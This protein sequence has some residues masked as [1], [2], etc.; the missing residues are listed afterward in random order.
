MIIIKPGYSVFKKE[1]KIFAHGIFFCLLFFEAKS[2]EIFEPVRPQKKIVPSKIISTINVD[3]RLDEAAWDSAKSINDFIEINPKQGSTPSQPTF[4]RI[5]YNNSYL[6]IAV[7]CMDKGGKKSIRATDFKRDFD[8]PYHDLFAIMIDGFKDARNAMAFLINPYGVQRDV[9]CFDDR[10]FDVE[11]DGLWKVRTQRT[12]SGWIAEIAIPW[13]TLRYPATAGAFQTWGIN[14]TRQRRSTNEYYSW[15]PF[16]R[17]YSLTR[18]SYEGLL[19]SLVVP[20]ASTNIRIQPYTLI[21]AEKEHL[22]SNWKEDVKEGGEI[23][24]ALASNKVLD[25][26]FN[27]DFAQADV[28]QQ[29]NN[30]QRFSIFFPERRQFFLENASLFKSGLDVNPDGNKG[31]QMTI[32]PFFS[33]KIG[34]DDNGNPI[35]IQAGAR[36]IQRGDKN[37]LGLMSV[38]QASSDSL[39]PA[40]FFIG[41]YTCGIGKQNQIGALITTRLQ[42]HAFNK[43]IEG[44][45]N[46][47]GTVDGFFR[48]SEKLQWN[49]MLSATS[50]PGKVEKGI[51][52]YSQVFYRND[53][54]NA[55]WNQSFVSRNYSPEIGFVNRSNI[56]CTSPGFYITDRG[57]W[58]PAFIR[59][60]DPGIKTDM[61][62]TLN[63]GKL[64]EINL[65]IFPV[66]FEFH[67]GGYAG[68]SWRYQYQLLYGNFEP[69]NAMIAPGKYTYSRLDFQCSS[70][71]S[72][73]WNL[74]AEYSFGSFYD[75][76]LQDINLQTRYSPVP[77]VSLTGGF[78]Q[79]LLRQVGIQKLSAIY[80]LYNLQVKLALNP[81][82]QLSVFYQKNTSTAVNGLNAKFSGEYKSL[83]YF[84]IVWNT[85]QWV[86]NSIKER[87]L[88]GILKLSYL[89]QF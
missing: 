74:K 34:L 49:G 2:Q 67:N 24:W 7:T 66:W 32:Q 58:L 46:W 75:G 71:P 47:S 22:Y 19:D 48:L 61:L 28:D 80:Y 33:R 6:Y 35:N 18:M 27:T 70:D 84:Y 56:I 79:Y 39:S 13:K 38:R 89:K 31:T 87:S 4:V 26:T 54:V 37:A 72:K 81:R 43:P 10:F 88:A 83:S 42:E 15:S 14:F 1:V 86:E 11:W 60:F 63:T 5:L 3:G 73:K 76:R 36:Y 41:R 82:I 62:H 12:D 9:L 77:Q 68:F 17:A 85:R 23:K 45:T 29:L 65:N 40:N 25:L 16:P 55:W 59:S 20:A 8:A 50:T 44:Y 78:E 57:K 64:E 51:A 69:L 21:S 52:G 30:L 53:Y